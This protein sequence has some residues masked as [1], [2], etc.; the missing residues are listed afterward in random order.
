[1]NDATQ[2]W[3]DAINGVS[4]SPAELA[5]KSKEYTRAFTAGRAWLESMTTKGEER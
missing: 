2:G 3:T 1:M 5:V 4:W